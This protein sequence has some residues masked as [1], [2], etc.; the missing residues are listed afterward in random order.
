[1]LG[2]CIAALCVLGVYSL[3]QSLNGLNTSV[4]G[5]IVDHM[6]DNHA[7][8]MVLLCKAFS[9]ARDV[10]E[11]RMTSI[12]R[13]GFEMSAVTAKGPRPVRLAFDSPVHDTTSARVAIV[14]MVKDA[15]AKLAD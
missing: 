13:Y 5:G 12:D 14:A 10:A 7:D 1:M 6:N 2:G 8:S 9:K 4:A 3:G 11:V 15:R